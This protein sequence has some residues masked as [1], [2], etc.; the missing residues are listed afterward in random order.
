MNYVWLLV[1]V[2]TGGAPDAKP[3]GHIF[4]EHK[5]E[6]QCRR[7]ADSLNEYHG[8]VDNRT[9]YATCVL[10]WPTAK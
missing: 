8:K 10:W 2:F 5:S 7:L 9:R 1:L 4:S 6:E 3:E